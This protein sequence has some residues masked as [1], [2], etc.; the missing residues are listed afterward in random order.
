MFP[1]INLI[2]ATCRIPLEYV[3]TNLG[4]G[5]I[6]DQNFQIFVL[7]RGFFST[8]FSNR[9]G[10]IRSQT[11]FYTAE[12]QWWPTVTTPLCV[13]GTFGWQWLSALCLL[14][15]ALPITFMYKPSLLGKGQ[16]FFSCHILRGYSGLWSNQSL[17]IFIEYILYKEVTSQLK[18][19]NTAFSTTSFP[20]RCPGASKAHRNLPRSPGQ[21]F[22][23]RGEEVGSRWGEFHTPHP[24]RF[25]PAWTL[26]W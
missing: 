11:Q 2:K 13:E 22:S 5:I 15:Q 16:W 20:G 21:D 3:V 18:L 1:E 12:T 17:T 6:L 8:W 19:S 25:P 23:N 7:I 9:R 26:W 4:E 14:V 10:P 24:Y